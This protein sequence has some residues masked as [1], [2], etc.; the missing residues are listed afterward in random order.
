MFHSFAGWFI[1][2]LRVSELGKAIVSISAIVEELENNT[3]DVSRAL[4]EEVTSLS[5]MVFQNLMGMGL[6]LALQGGVCTIINASCWIYVDR[7]QKYLGEN[8]N[9]T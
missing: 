4:Q 1:P 7:S 9:L 3:L 2:W 8:Q 6:L 5:E